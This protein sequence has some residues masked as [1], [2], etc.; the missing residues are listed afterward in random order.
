MEMFISH[1]QY[2][3]MEFC[4][5]SH[6]ILQSEHLSSQC[7]LMLLSTL[8]P[9]LHCLHKEMNDHAHG[10]DNPWKNVWTHLANTHSISDLFSTC[11]YRQLVEPKSGFLLCLF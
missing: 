9:P 8:M 1:V 6:P 11:P 7:F 3:C 5:Q 4:Y 10:G 2:T